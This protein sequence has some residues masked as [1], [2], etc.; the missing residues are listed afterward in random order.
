MPELAKRT[1]CTGCTAC[2]SICPKQCIKMVADEHG[3][4]YPEIELSQCVNCMLCVKSCPIQTGGAALSSEASAYAAY[5]N[6]WELRKDSSSGGIFSELAIEILKKGGVVFGAAYDPQFQIKHVCVETI[7][8]LSRLRGAKYAQSAL[9]GVF[10]QVKEALQK[11]REV[12][13]SGTP[14]QIAGLKAFLQKEYESLTCVDFVCH[15]VPS[16]AVWSQYVQYRSALDGDGKLPTAVN[17]RDKESGWSRYQYS[18]VFRYEGKRWSSRNQDNLFMRLFVGD[19]INRLSC[20]HCKAK[21]YHRVSDITLGDFWGIW[22]VRPEM[23][24]DKGTSLVILHSD[25]GRALFDA[26]HDRIRYQSVSLE[27]ASLRN[28]SLLE[29]S[30]AK[31]EREAFLTKALAGAFDE[32]EK[33]LDQS[34]ACPKRSLLHRVGGWI[35]RI[36]SKE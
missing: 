20:E 9:D 33:H 15:G 5:T 28:P 12:L 22:E 11:Q 23:D 4:V 29:S 7:E 34:A 30:R 6:H 27:E 35:R 16:P 31:E 13:F 25:K 17:M 36:G 32:L 18:N 26:I 10:A 14:C 19:Y 3:F 1:E 24:D 2:A 21:G 8:G